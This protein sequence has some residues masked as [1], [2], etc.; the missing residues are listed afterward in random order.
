MSLLIN[1]QRWSSSLKLVLFYI[2]R[3][4]RGT[5][6]RYQTITSLQSQN[7]HKHQLY[8]LTLRRK[9]FAKLSARCLDFWTSQ[10]ALLTANQLLL[11]DSLVAVFDECRTLFLMCLF[12][13]AGRVCALSDDWQLRIWQ[14][15]W[16]RNI[17]CD[18]YNWCVTPLSDTSQS[19]TV[20]AP[21]AV[22]RRG[23]SL[24]GEEKEKGSDE[25]ID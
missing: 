20:T 22:A 4:T 19:P 11:S 10:A 8:F 23:R 7:S 2:I 24:S 25:R 1:M 18:P 15:I 3:W 6:E 9:P 17:T 21:G 14:T 12:W 16:M 5:S 13:Y